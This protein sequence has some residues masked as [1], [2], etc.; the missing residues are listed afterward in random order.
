ME[1]FYLETAEN[2]ISVNLVNTTEFHEFSELLDA[3]DYFRDPYNIDTFTEASVV[4]SP[5]KRNIANDVAT[6]VKNTYKTTKDVYR[7]KKDITDGGAAIAG[8]LWNAGAAGMNIIAR[9]A[10]FIM[11]YLSYV[12]NAIAKALQTVAD[13]PTNVV[14]KIRGNIKLYITVEDL[15]LLYRERLM[16]KLDS[17]LSVAER[18][19]QGEAWNYVKGTAI[20][21]KV[22]KIFTTT[23]DQLCKTLNAYYREIG[24]LQFEPT[25]IDMSNPANVTTYFAADKKITFYDD[26]G[27]KFSGNYFEAINK[28]AKDLLA[29]KNSIR[30]T[31]ESISDKYNKSQAALNFAELSKSEQTQILNAINSISSMT[32]VIGNIVKYILTDMDTFYRNLSKVN[33]HNKKGT[34]A[35]TVNKADVKRE[36]KEVK[37]QSKENK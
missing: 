12:P 33:G 4:G 36:K 35:K 25:V 26:R 21:K 29:R 14:N 1:D 19:A 15:S 7:F 22:K 2:L 28:L 13:L 9:L 17:F 30:S 10:G 34:S 27:N 24:R 31:Y 6:T 11:K 20:V 37:S 16:T 3:L 5:L 8:G 32:S 23:D 18:L